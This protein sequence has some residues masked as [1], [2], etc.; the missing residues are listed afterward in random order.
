MVIKVL[1]GGCAKCD[2]LEAATKEAL[3]RLGL[4]AEVEHVRDFESIMAY[5]VM[6]T[7]ALVIDEEV[8]LSGRVPKVDELIGLLE[9][10]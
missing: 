7:P 3:E 4:N 10:A 9:R 6:A 1:G 8:K 5:G 2:Q